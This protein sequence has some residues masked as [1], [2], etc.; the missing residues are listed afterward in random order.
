MATQ[1]KREVP[2]SARMAEFVLNLTIAND[3]VMPNWAA[4]VVVELRPKEGVTPE[5]TLWQVQ[6][7]AQDTGATLV[8]YG[9]VQDPNG[10]ARELL[11]M[12]IPLDKM[13][14]FAQWGRVKELSAPAEFPVLTMNNKGKADMSEID[15]SVSGWQDMV[16]DAAHGITFQVDRPKAASVV[17]VAPVQTAVKEDPAF[18]F[19]VTEEISEVKRS[20]PVASMAASAPSVPNQEVFISEAV[21]RVAQ[22][23]AKTVL[24]RMAI[25]PPVSSKQSADELRD[26]VGKSR[27]VVSGYATTFSEGN[28]PQ[29]VALVKLPA[30]AVMS[31]QHVPGIQMLFGASETMQEAV[32]ARREAAN[33]NMQQSVVAPV[34]VDRAPPIRAIQSNVASVG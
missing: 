27:G 17:A 32:A 5:M 1:E 23:A 2:Y 28:K 29:D 24:V 12:K 25:N 21:Q 11:H 14:G 34:R 26:F 8:N 16:A 13:E 15:R 3:G 4:P 9:S 20:S 6:Q 30:W 31:L 22:S 19:E 7:Y 10:E 18:D 33:A